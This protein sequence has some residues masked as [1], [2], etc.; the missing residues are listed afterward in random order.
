V[1]YGIYESP[2]IATVPV[3][4]AAGQVDWTTEVAVPSDVTGLY[5]MLSV[6]SKRQRLFV[7]YAI[8]LTAS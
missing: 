4:P 7:N 3:T 8:D 5:M 2:D 6:E 1:L